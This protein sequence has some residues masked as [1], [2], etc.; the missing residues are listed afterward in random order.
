MYKVDLNDTMDSD[1]YQL[2]PDSSPYQSF[3]DDTDSTQSPEIIFS[4][5]SDENSVIDEN[6]DNKMI[7]LTIDGE[8]AGIVAGG[9]NDIDNHG[10][11]NVVLANNNSGTNISASTSNNGGSDNGGGH[12]FEGAEKRLAIYFKEDSSNKVLDLR[13]LTRSQWKN[14]LDLVHCQI[15]NIKSNEHFDAYLLSESSLFVSKR[16]FILKTCGSTTLLHCLD[17]ILEYVYKIGFD[18]IEDVFY[19]HKNLLLPSLQRLP[20]NSF[21][22]ESEY[23]DKAFNGHSHLFGHINADRWYLYLLDYRPELDCND[24]QQQQQQQHPNQLINRN[25]FFK[26]EMIMEELDEDVMQ[27]FFNDPDMPITAAQVTR[28][29]GIDSIIPGM[30]ID[31]Y[32]FSPCG[33]SMNGLLSEYYMTIHITPEQ[34]FS[35]VSVEMNVPQ[36]SYISFMAKVIDVF[37]PG[38]FMLN[39]FVPSINNLRSK[40]QQFNDSMM[41]MDDGIGIGLGK[42]YV[43]VGNDRQKIKSSNQCLFETMQMHGLVMYEALSCVS[44]GQYRRCDFQMAQ[45]EH[46]DIIYARFVSEGIS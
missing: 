3:N 6:I 15:L 30:V 31:D 20:H 18:T 29:S 12:F 27:L 33:Y 5:S 43:N 17:L 24:D 26:F 19:S 40:Q 16:S 38:K 39:L 42:N 35:Y 46:L 37:K 34:E 41:I 2:S 22:K 13:K 25:E 44:I 32:L 28:K 21:L 10:N 4:T 45:T 8:I 9:G 14:I 36:K 23:L 1:S 11:Q 7:T